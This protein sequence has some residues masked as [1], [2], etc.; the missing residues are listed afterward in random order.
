MNSFWLT[1]LNLN[2]GLILLN[3]TVSMTELGNTIPLAMGVSFIIFIS[4]ECSSLYYVTPTYL[5]NVLYLAYSFHGSGHY[6]AC[7]PCGDPC[8]SDKVVKCRCGVNR[9][10]SIKENFIACN[11]GTNARHSTCKCLAASQAC[12]SLC[13]CKDCK[14]PN[15]QRTVFG[16]REIFTIGRRSI[17]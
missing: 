2:H 9:R 13:K 17:L 16:K 5:A 15:G 12:S 1:V 11:N 6:D 10:E 14:N 8:M 7:V 3:K 4:H